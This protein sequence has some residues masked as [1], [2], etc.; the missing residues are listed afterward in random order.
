MGGKSSVLDSVEIVRST[1]YISMKKITKKF[2]KKKK[3]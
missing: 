3:L 2:K 1:N